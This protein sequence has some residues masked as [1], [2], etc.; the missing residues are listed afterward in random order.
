M[1]EL[2]HPA[3]WWSVL[4]PFRF[5]WWLAGISPVAAGLVIIYGLGLLT[6]PPQAW[7]L[8]F[9]NPPKGRKR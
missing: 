6:M 7:G 1:E 9:N 2:F 8:L 3:L 4:L 5:L